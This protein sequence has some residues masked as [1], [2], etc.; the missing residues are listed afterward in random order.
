VPHKIG[1]ALAAGNSVILKPALA[2]PLTAIALVQ[3]FVDA[4]LPAGVL[5]LV[6]GPASDLGSQLVSD[7]RV[8][9][10][11]GAN[12]RTSTWPL[13][14]ALSRESESIGTEI[15]ESSGSSPQGEFSGLP[16]IEKAP[17]LV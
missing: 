13:R 8:R 2:A 1:P 15:E 6:N 10:T 4:G 9:G 14:P 16:D 7:A 12:R 3:C 5:G 11:S 17:R